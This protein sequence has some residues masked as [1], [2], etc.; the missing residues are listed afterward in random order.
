LGKN[1]ASPAESN[2]DYVD[3]VHK[4]GPYA[5]YLVINI[6]S[7]N[8]PGLRDLQKTESLRRLIKEAQDARNTLPSPLPPLLVKIAPDLSDEEAK[9]ISSVLKDLKVD[10]VI[11]SNTTISRPSTLKSGLTDPKTVAQVGGLSGPP[12][13]PLAVSLVKKIYSLTEGKIPIV[14]C[15]GISS[16]Q[17]AVDFAKAGASLVQFYT[18]L[19]YRGPG[20][21]DEIKREVTELL[22]K[23]N[24]TWEKIIGQDHRN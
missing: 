6:S 13:K 1:K 15:G 12:V 17:D 22:E 19:G 23:E 10:G 14:G 7:P 24:T 2:Q 8:T 3:G 4:L 20:A 9:D 21:T 5:D 18:H 16:G 11:I